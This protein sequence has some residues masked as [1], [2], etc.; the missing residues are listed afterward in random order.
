MEFHIRAKSKA[1]VGAA[2]V[3]LL[4]G[5]AIY[6]LFRSQSMLMFRWVEVFGLSEALAIAR[7][8]L[9]PLK[10]F[11]PHW[12]L[13]SAPFALW[14]F[15]Y[16][17]VTKAIWLRTSSSAKHLWCWSVPVGSVVVECGQLTTYVPGSFDSIDVLTILIVT[18]VT[19]VLA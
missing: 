6:L 13:F 12:V 8:N 4:V 19:L 15:S 7:F 17:L 5:S 10:A 16:L 9:A 2:A 11:L 1:Y 18:L 3:T 14:V